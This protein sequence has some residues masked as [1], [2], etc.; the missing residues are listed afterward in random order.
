M[1]GQPHSPINLLLGKDPWYP[2]H[3][4]LCGPLSQFGCFGDGTD[5][6]KII[7]LFLSSSG[8]CLIYIRS[9]FCHSIQ[10][11][12]W[13]LLN[14][15][16]SMRCF[17]MPW[18]NR[19]KPQFKWNNYWQCASECIEE[20]DSKCSSSE[21]ITDNEFSTVLPPQYTIMQQWTVPTRFQGSQCLLFRIKQ[22]MVAD[23][24][25]DDDDAIIILWNRRNS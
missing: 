16:S 5:P 17:R 2:L 21:T 19:F 15:I 20:T 6:S 12:Q 9:H 11:I 14:T 22:S 23:P 4:R 24:D 25:D 3:K 13:N 10:I 8:N 18:R 1:S 7:H